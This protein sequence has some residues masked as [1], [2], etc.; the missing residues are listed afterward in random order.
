MPR[1][2][3]NAFVIHRT[4]WTGIGWSRPKRSR[5]AAMVSGERSSPASTAAGS[6]GQEELQAEHDDAEQEQRGEDAAGPAR[7]A[8]SRGPPGEEA[9]LEPAEP[10]AGRQP[11][12]GRRRARRAAPRRRGSRRWRGRRSTGAS[13][14]S[15][16]PAG[17]L[18]HQAA[19]G[20]A[21]AGAGG[22]PSPADRMGGVGPAAGP[23]DRHRL[24]QLARIGVTRRAEHRLDRP[25]LDDPPA[26]H[27]RDAVDDVPDDAEVV[28]D[29]HHATGA[30]RAGCRRG[31]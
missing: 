14:G 30:A 2:P 17:V 9:V 6:P 26:I 27:H 29:E 4:Y 24:E 5:M 7:G 20:E 18:R 1:S 19:A 31:G 13:S 28:R 22:A 16:L 3:W 21:A 8:A 23:G 10:L 15:L 11:A 25:A 12:S